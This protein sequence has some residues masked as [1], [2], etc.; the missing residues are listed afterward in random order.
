MTYGAADD[1]EARY[2]RRIAVLIGKDGRIEH[3][4]DRV[5]A[6]SFADTVLAALAV[7]APAEAIR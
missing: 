4:W 7:N 1:A 3:R 5:R 2:A 6:R